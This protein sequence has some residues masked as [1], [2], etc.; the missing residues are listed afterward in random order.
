MKPIEVVFYQIHKEPVRKTIT[1]FH[2]MWC[3]MEAPY[4]YIYGSMD[5]KRLHVQLYKLYV[6]EAFRGRIHYHGLSKKD[7]RLSL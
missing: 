2:L 7:F 6:Y 3:H 1:V 5:L 4:G